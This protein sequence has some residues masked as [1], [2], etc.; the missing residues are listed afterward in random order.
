MTGS[1]LSSARAHLADLRHRAYVPFSETPRCVLL[2][3]N[4][5]RWIP[6]VRIESASYSLT[7][8]ALGNAVTTAY[9]LRCFDAIAGVIAT[10]PLSAADQ[11][12]L[13]ELEDFEAPVRSSNGTTSLAAYWR[14][15]PPSTLTDAVDPT[16]PVPDSPDAGIE[17][18]RAVAA[19]AYI[20]ESRFPVGAVFV[21]DDR[22]AVPGVNVEHPDWT[23]ILCAER[24][25]LSTAYAYGF[26]HCTALYLSCPKA[27]QGSPCGAC[28]QVLAERATEATLYMDRHDA[29]AEQ[30]TPAE[31]LPS[32][33][34]SSDL[35]PD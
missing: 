22:T 13:H 32:F 27:R 28:R 1:L 23:R 5:G 14:S 35:I 9:S 19:N 17:A 3:L 11:T 24:N 2:V 18:A 33:F 6:G 10:H 15:D 25:A 7:I 16:L 29:P 30:T 8:S 26:T 31:L 20:P 34:S 4:D 21:H 12:Y